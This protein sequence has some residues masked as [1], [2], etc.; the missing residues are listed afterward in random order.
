MHKD[1]E[2]SAR[3]TADLKK[4]GVSKY[5]LF[6][7]ETAELP[8]IIAKDE[9]I[10]GCI[11]GQYG[12][13]SGMIVATDRRIIFLDK[14][15]MHLLLEEMTF[16]KI[17]DIGADWQPLFSR[18]TINGRAVKYVF[19]YVNTKCARIF[20]NYLETAVL[21][22]HTGPMHRD[23]KEHFYKVTIP[24]NLSLEENQFLAT[25]YMGV[26]SSICPD[27][28]PYGAT[29]FYFVDKK[30]NDILRFVTKSTTVTAGNVRDR[31]RV[32]LTVTDQEKLATL[33]ISGD[34][35]LEEDLDLAYTTLKQLLVKNPHI[36]EGVIPPVAQIKDGSY[37]VLKIQIAKSYLR[38]Y[39]S[40][41]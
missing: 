27:G 40:K 10:Y 29:M 16:D 41:D 36:P 30:S 35:S 6:K 13:G 15:P 19:R 3:I 34:A 21:G 26:V 23:D 11:Y 7:A 22:L 1:Q 32:A 24:K 31:R 12:E 18:V 17:I 9:V 20:V 5:G 8:N 14:K 38:V 4:V 28:Y 39:K 33:H 25:H 2:H 37:V